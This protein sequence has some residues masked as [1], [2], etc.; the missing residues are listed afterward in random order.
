M[1]QVAPGA[2]IDILYISVGAEKFGAPAEVP[3][4]PDDAKL[5]LSNILR[6]D[7]PQNDYK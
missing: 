5:C 6:W 2:D 3:R 7:S 4:A 1:A